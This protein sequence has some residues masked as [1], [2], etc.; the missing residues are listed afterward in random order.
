[1]LN[2]ILK[3]ARS[4][5]VEPSCPLCRQPVDAFASGLPCPDCRRRLGIPSAVLKGEEPLPWQALAHYSGTVRTFVIR[6]RKAPEPSR[7]KGLVQLL[8]DRCTV[9]K[10]AVLVSIPSWR[11]RQRRSFA[12][13]IATGLGMEHRPILRRTRAGVGQ[14]NLNRQQRLANLRGAFRVDNT[15][16][17]H[18]DDRIIWLVDDILTT[19]GTAMAARSALEASGHRVAGL[20]CLARTPSP[21]RDLRCRRR[22]GDTPG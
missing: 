13:L 5:L 4:L 1:M 10:D 17:A 12:D 18:N 9:E 19:G 15:G 14:H 22:Q 3:A 20:I 11:R 8:A 16:V 6:Q 7:L 21:G 2:G